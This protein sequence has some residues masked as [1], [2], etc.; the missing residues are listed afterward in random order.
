MNTVRAELHRQRR[1]RTRA[2]AASTI[3][4]RENSRMMR[5]LFVF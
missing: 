5:M 4:D 1:V 2:H 3:T